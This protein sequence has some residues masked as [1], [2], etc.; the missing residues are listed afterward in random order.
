M[1]YD[2]FSHRHRMKK[3]KQRYVVR[4]SD[5]APVFNVFTGAF[6]FGTPVLHSQ[7]RMIMKEKCP[8]LFR[9]RGIYICRRRE[10]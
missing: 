1:Q 2:Y 5:R 7:R 4:V 10:L 8:M 6:N 3:P 9:A